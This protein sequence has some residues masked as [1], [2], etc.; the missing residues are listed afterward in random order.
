MGSAVSTRSRRIFLVARVSIGGPTFVEEVSGA[1]GAADTKEDLMSD[2][3]PG[4]AA[5]PASRFIRS[6]AA[7]TVVAGTAAAA[8]T[9]VAAAAVHAGGVP[10]AVGRQ[11]IPLA[12]FAQMTLLGAVIGGIR[13]AT[14]NR[15]SFVPAS[16]SSKPPPRLPASHACPRRPGRP[17]PPPRPLW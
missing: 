4:P 15:R 13:L 6:L 11:M 10:L 8:G 17:T 9:T 3:I 7:P 16:A 2:T 1:S 14:F 12:G 5:A